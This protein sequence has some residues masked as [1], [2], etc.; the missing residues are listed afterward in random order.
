[1][2]SK[3]QFLTLVVLEVK[4]N[5]KK[6]SIIIPTQMHFPN[7]LEG[8]KYHSWRGILPGSYTRLSVVC[9]ELEGVCAECHYVRQKAGVGD[10]VP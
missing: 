2:H 7:S 5:N 4:T 10:D 8:Y 3:K 6:K 9:G 1:M